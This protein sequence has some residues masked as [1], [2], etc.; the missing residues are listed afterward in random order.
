MASKHDWIV[1]FQSKSPIYDAPYQKAPND[2]DHYQ[3]VEINHGKA[4]YVAVPTEE[5]NINNEKR[6]LV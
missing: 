2:E 3:P 1:S 4:T 5:P 6:S